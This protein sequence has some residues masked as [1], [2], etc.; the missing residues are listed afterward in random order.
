MRQATLIG[1]VFCFAFLAV[2]QASGEEDGVS[3]KSKVVLTS[4]EKEFI[5]QLG[6]NKDELDSLMQSAWVLISVGYAGQVPMPGKNIKET[7]DNFAVAV[8]KL[9]AS[10]PVPDDVY[11]NAAKALKQMAA[12]PIHD[13][14][15]L[16]VLG[17]HPKFKGYRPKGENWKFF[18]ALQQ[19]FYRITVGAL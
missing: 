2:S 6:R 12:K 17:Q 14:L 8:A 10:K 5:E 9:E 19:R 3:Y 13:E 7:I 11:A 16:F 18:K 1:G 15:T 4:T